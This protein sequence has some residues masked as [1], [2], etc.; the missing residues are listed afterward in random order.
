MGLQTRLEQ[1]DLINARGETALEKTTFRQ[2][3][4]ERRRGLLR[5]ARVVPEAAVSPH[6]GLRG[7]RDQ[8][9]Q[10]NMC[11]AQLHRALLDHGYR[12][13]K[14]PIQGFVRWWRRGE[15][16]EETRLEL[17]GTQRLTGENLAT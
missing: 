8:L 11:V 5:V 1:G 7:T 17:V 4:L 2:D 6:R 16:L 15:H 13:S 3:L 9:H 12:G 14:S 10:G